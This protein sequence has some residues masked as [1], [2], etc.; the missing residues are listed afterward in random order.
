M[1][2]ALTSVQRQLKTTHRFA[3]ASFNVSLQKTSS[4]VAKTKCVFFGWF[5]NK[6]ALMFKEK[7]KEN[8]H[9]CNVSSC[10]VVQ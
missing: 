9:R 10:D 7:P 8:S 2:F 6:V 3:E 4:S 5:P 1:T